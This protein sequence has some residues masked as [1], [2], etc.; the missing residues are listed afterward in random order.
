MTA[1]VLVLLALAAVPLA[2]LGVLAWRS[3]TLAVCLVPLCLPFG[4]VTVHGLALKLAQVA[5][6][7]AGALVLW[8]RLA[9]G[10]R[11][12]PVS[13][14]L[15]GSGLAVLGALCSTFV[16]VAPTAAI[17][18]DLG[19]LIGLGLATATAT[20]CVQPRAQRAVLACLCATGGAACAA[21][22]STAGRLRVFY[23]GALVQNRATGPFGQPNELGSLSVT[24]S[25]VGLG[26]L[27]ALPSGRRFRPLRLLAGAASLA[28][29]AALT[30]SFSRGA[31]IGLALGLAVLVL[32]APRS[33]RPVLAGFAA[34][35][36]VG[37][38]SPF[39]VPGQAVLAAVGDRLAATA[40]GE[41]NPY[42][43]RPAIWREAV[44]QAEGSPVLGVGPGGYPV[45]ATLDESAARVSA[46]EHAHNVVLT[47]AAEQGAV[48]LL[49]FALAVFAGIGGAARTARR[50]DR[51][52][53]PNAEGRGL[54]A[55]A[56]AGLAALIGQGLVD[57]T[58]RNALL[59]TVL[60]LLVGLL[61]AGCR[62]RPGQLPGPVAPAARPHAQDGTRR[63]PMARTVEAEQRE[64]ERTPAH[65]V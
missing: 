49:G 34:V 5:A 6:L 15:L 50:Y 22:L 47:I 56:A 30:L 62:A 26:L 33:R 10:R 12:L 1:T 46:P 35:A 48:G 16:A 37:L 21:G 20:A 55:A 9:L 14:V 53:D 31:W 19:Y 8:R 43:E 36:L 52:P 42:D 25:V 3:P 57:Y 61:A 11:Q 7:S 4:L 28:A 63:L 39:L 18:L 59:G 40:T 23:G 44:R 41:R 2:L 58:W 38:L 54:L 60:W 32:L 24:V 27:F 13:G 64:Q 51:S 29:M 17:R 65:V 45:R